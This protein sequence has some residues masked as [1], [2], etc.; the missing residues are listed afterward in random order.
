MFQWKLH[1][2][3]IQKICFFLL[4]DDS[5]WDEAK[6]KTDCA[7]L[8]KLSQSGHTSP[9]PATWNANI[10]IV[11]FIRPHYWYVTIVNCAP[12]PISTP[13]SIKYQLLMLQ[14]DGNQFSFDE[15]GILPMY[16]TFMCVLF[17]MLVVHLVADY[18][19]IKQNAFHPL[20]RLLTLS[21]SIEL[22]SLVLYISHYAVY[23]KDGVGIPS[24]KI[25]A[26]IFDFF[27]VL[28]FTLLVMLIATGWGITYPT[29]EHLKK[30]WKVLG[31]FLAVFLVCY[32]AILIWE[33]FSTDISST[34]LYVSPPGI[35]FIVIRG[36]NFIYFGYL[37]FQT[38][39]EEGDDSKRKFYIFF[40]FMYGLWILALPLIVLMATLVSAY[41]RIKWVMG[42]YYASSL[43]GMF[44]LVVCLWPS[45]AAK[46]FAVVVPD[47]FS[48]SHGNYEK[49]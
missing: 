49:L 7:S 19:L 31:A 8:V 39:R 28:I 21:I 10:R 6:S 34:Y 32:V 9:L 18:Q 24:M 12:I 14:P 30:H 27:F 25:F 1:K 35:I 42:V 37:L 48:S 20:I 40:G 41:L 22:L 2:D 33:I 3:T 45:R 38:L 17:V 29:L 4:F 13:V 23:S 5:H 47:V 16:I 15:L 11:D 46:Y 43:L 36:I 44:I 26:Q